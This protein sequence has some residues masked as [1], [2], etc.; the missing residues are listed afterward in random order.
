MKKWNEGQIAILDSIGRDHNIL[1]SAAAG[2]GKT[3]VMVERIVNSVEQGLCGID[4]ILVVTF[5][6]A[7]AAQMKGKIT[8]ELEDRAYDSGDARLLRQ[9]SLAANADIST[10][11]SFCNRVVRENFQEAGV[12]P[13][14]DILDRGEETLL[15]EDV[16]DGVLERLYRDPEFAVF[17]QA[18]FRKT[19]E[20][21]TLRNLIRKVHQVSQGFADPEGWLKRCRPDPENLLAAA[22][23]GPW[24]EGLLREVKNNAR[25]IEGFLTAEIA[26]YAAE[27]DSDRKKVAGKVVDALKKDLEL[28]D[29]V[30]NAGDLSEAA[31]AVK[32]TIGRFPKKDYLLAYPELGTMLPESR[33]EQLDTLRKPLKGFDEESLLKELQYISVTE[34]HLLRAVRLF[35]EELMREKKRRKKY[36][37]NDIAHFAYRV[38]RDPETGEVTPIGERYAEKYR[39]IYIDE[40]Q[41]GS[42]MQEHI[43]NS[44]AR[45]R[46]GKP[47]N[48]FMVGDVKQSIYR[49]RQARPQLFLE[50]EA[51]YKDGGAGEVLYLNRNYR[52]RNEI[53]RACN[54]VFRRLMRPDFGGIDYDENVQLNPPEDRED[55]WDPDFLP[56][57]LLSDPKT[58]DED[59]EDVQSD[60]LEARLI[61]RK[62]LELVE[63]KQ[64]YG[65]GDIVILQRSVKGCGSMLKEY[66]R[67]G[68]PV[69]L[70]DPS[71][72]FDAEEVVVLLSLLQLIDN[73][74]QDIPYAAVLRSPIGGCND[75]ELAGLAM[76]R[77]DRDQ[78]LFDVA[79]RLLED[80]P[81]VPPSLEELTEGLKVKLQQLHTRL[82]GWKRDSRYLSIDRLVE[83]V[84]EETGYRQVVA[85]MPEGDRRL[86]NL[87][88]LCYKAEEFEKAGNHGL[89]T[90]LRYI[91]QCKIHQVD[92][93]DDGSVSEGNDAVRICTMH[94]SKGLEF[95]VVFVARLGKQFNKKDTAEKI[96][97]S[98]DYGLA[99]K[100]IR[101]AAGKYWLMQDGF[102]NNTVNYLHMQETRFEELRLLYV[103]MTRAE[104]RLYLTGVCRDL[105]KK[106]EQKKT[107]TYSDKTKAAGFLDFLLP[108]LSQEGIGEYIRTYTYDALSLEAVSPLSTGE[109]EVASPEMT[110]DEAAEAAA[111]ILREQ[112]A[113][114]YPYQA[115]VVTRTKL[116]VSEVKHEAMEKKGISLSAGPQKP[117]EA[118]VDGGKQGVEAEGSKQRVEAEGAKQKAAS[119]ITGADY[120]TAVHK[121]MELLP[122]DRIGSRKEMRETLK[123]LLAGP[124]FTEDL[125]KVLRVDKIEQFYSDAPDSLFQRMK[126][127]KERGD[128]H[129]EQQFLIGLPARRLGQEI[130]LQ[131]EDGEQ[132]GDGHFA[133]EE[134][135]VLQGIIDG[136][137]LEKDE[138]G[139]PYAVLMD[140]KTDRVDHPEQLIDRYY[141]QMS[142]YRETIEDILQ[143]PV[144]EMWLYGF[145]AGLGEIRIPDEDRKED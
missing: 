97:V 26:V 87:S 14:F 45:T 47:C 73:S 99:P 144:R 85:R 57:V 116:S 23:S 71:A 1:V 22:L 82:A 115:A 88:Q 66:A 103:A 24:A 133:T 31:R 137:F 58:G 79:G 108:I 55:Q 126:R 42:D 86:A 143:V 77:T 16:M 75:A 130:P 98:A 61:G 11:D 15:K 125:R 122:F 80:E 64:Q 124:F 94:S 74:R 33:S 43:L 29:S 46:D 136:F 67:L 131:E 40:Y 50:K 101:K 25:S 89:F 76:H 39:Y 118:E 92:F 128:L 110:P 78:S 36:E 104:D 60:V 117:A 121:L 65:F 2:S 48:I 119:G 120:G 44:V 69:R 49:F 129:V 139:Q 70:E 83:R 56:E 59:T 111:A 17:A 112:Y 106:R 32:G 114:T 105:E 4:E 142:L 18:F 9:L 93:A 54:E 63:E 91:D 68:I 72:Y 84:L 35:Q 20:D 135:V 140:Y 37:F 7:A 34:E 13:G 62:I 21:T 102:V 95:P 81:E 12:D 109:E 113:Y 90:F 19:R 145:S 134:P 53:L 127:A 138:E 28:V 8:K 5:T 107:L 100:V 96:M 38:L 27:T 30:L 10:I 123:E 41:D 51:A 3:S 6:K 52:S 132:V 141:A